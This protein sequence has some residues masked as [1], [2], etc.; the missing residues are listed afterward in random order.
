M[1]NLLFIF[2]KGEGPTEPLSRRPEKTQI[3]KKG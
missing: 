2:S 3:I 1:E